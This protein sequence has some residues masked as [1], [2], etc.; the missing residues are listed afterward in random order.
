MN[1]GLPAYA[2]AI[3]PILLFSDTTINLITTFQIPG[4]G[5]NSLNAN[6]AGTSGDALPWEA[7]VPIA[8]T[9]VNEA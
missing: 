9:I 7:G 6:T 3:H 8:F 1:L 5:M 2:V 4:S